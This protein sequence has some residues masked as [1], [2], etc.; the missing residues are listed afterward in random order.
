MPD[1]FV[2]SVHLFNAYRQFIWPI[3]RLLAKGSIAQRCRTC[4]ASIKM[5]PLE[6]NGKCFLCNH[7]QDPNS[8]RSL[9]NLEE[10]RRKFHELLSQT[11]GSGRRAYDALILFSGGK[12][13]T[14]MVQRLKLEYPRLRI[15]AL[16]INNGFMSPIAEANTRDLVQKLGIDHY[17]VKVKR[18][19]Y[20]KLFR[21]G[22]THLNSHGAYGTVDFSDGE[23]TLDS[24]RNLA[25]Q[26]EIPLILC[27][28]SR[29]QVQDGLKLEDFE[30][31]RANE[32]K[33]RTSVAEL[34]LT[35]IFD[36]NEINL[37]WRGSSWPKERVPRLVFP[38]YIW[39][40]E[41]DEIKKQVDAWGLLSNR[42]SN[43][44]LTNH[45]LIPLFA[46]TDIHQRGFSSFEPEFCRMIREGKADLAHWRSTFEFLEYTA[47]TGMFIKPLIHQ[48]LRDL[49]LTANELGIHFSW[50][51]QV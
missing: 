12:D 43:P 48:L 50:R 37:W 10:Q 42:M 16:T 40:L 2:L 23:F 30:S 5:T 3:H 11:Q 44:A 24:G 46:V 33:D 29:Y 20:V 32:T 47:R 14:Y 39:D 19:F 27:G 25:A 18:Q 26:L 49:N 36:S 6:P 41:E 28:Y 13:S 1:S 22:L 8:Q 51:K 45:R 31:P 4:A 7:P 17:F 34:P 21:Y 38:L 9:E 35:E 15:L